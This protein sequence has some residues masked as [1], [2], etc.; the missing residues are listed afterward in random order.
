MQ[1]TRVLDPQ[2]VIKM[3]TTTFVK[4][5][6]SIMY[7]TTQEMVSQVCT[8]YKRGVGVLCENKM[9]DFV[10]GDPLQEANSLGKAITEGLNF[11]LIPSQNLCLE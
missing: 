6:T 4:S 5:S 1:G 9:T 8:F 11:S 7:R 3:S 2:K 10:R